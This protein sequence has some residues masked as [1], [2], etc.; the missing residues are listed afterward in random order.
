MRW[1][2]LLAVQVFSVGSREDLHE[3]GETL[4]DLARSEVGA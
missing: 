3:I 2:C 4:R 1:P